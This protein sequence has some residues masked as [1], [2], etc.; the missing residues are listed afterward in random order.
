MLTK[1]IRSF[2]HNLKTFTSLE[3]M[4][5]YLRTNRPAQNI[6]YF[7]ANWNPQCQESDKEIIRV[8]T[9][10]PGLD[11]I[12][13]DSD[14]APKI[15]K[16]YAVKAEPEFVFCL[17]GDEVIRQIGLN[18]QGLNE[19][20]EK[21]EKLGREVDLSDIKERWTEYGTSYKVFEDI[22]IKPMYKLIYSDL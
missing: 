6:V 16:H 3:E 20:I 2:V 4:N 15:A 21:V 17:F 12:K 10:N 14:A 11:I 18:P 1:S 19:K 7:R 13:I 8:A 5:S 22:K 9:E